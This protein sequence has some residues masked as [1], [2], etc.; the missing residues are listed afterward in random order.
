MTGG[1]IICFLLKGLHAKNYKHKIPNHN[2]MKKRTCKEI[3]YVIY[4]Q[5]ILISSF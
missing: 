4:I 1:E 3:H 2:I 5:F